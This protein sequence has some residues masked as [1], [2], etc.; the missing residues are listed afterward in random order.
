MFDKKR[1]LLALFVYWPLCLSAAATPVLSFVGTFDNATRIGPHQDVALKVLPQSL[2]RPGPKNRQIANFTE[3]PSCGLVVPTTESWKQYHTEI[4]KWFEEQWVLFQKNPGYKSLPLYLRDQFAPNAAPSSQFCDTF[5]TCSIISCSNL[6]EDLSQHDKQMAYFVFEQ[7]SGLDHMFHRMSKKLKENRKTEQLIMSIVQAYGLL[8]AGYVGLDIPVIPFK[9][10]FLFEL[11]IYLGISHVLNT[12]W[13]EVPNIDGDLEASFRGSLNEL[14]HRSTQCIT[15]EMRDFMSGETNRLEQNMSSIMKGEDFFAPDPNLTIRVKRDCEKIMFAV[16]VNALWRFDRAYILDTDAPPSGCESDTRGPSQ[17]R[18]CLPEF[19]KK[20]FWLYALNPSQEGDTSDQAQAS[21][22]IG[23]RNFFNETERYYN[24]TMKD[25]VR[26]SLFTHQNGL[27]EAI[28]KIDFKRMG[29]AASGNKTLGKVPATFTVPVC[30]NPGGE[31]ITSVW[32]DKGR[33]YPC[34]CGEF[35]WNDGTWSI[36][37]DETKKFL[38]FSSFM[39]SEDWEDYCSSHNHCKGQNDIDWHSDFERMRKEGDPEIPED[40]KHPFKKC[41]ESKKHSI[42]D[43]D[44]DFDNK[45]RAAVEQD[46]GDEKGVKL[47]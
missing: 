33:N 43:P 15:Q 30:R 18:V 12:A 32:S 16:A 21:G 4:K 6:K 22:P 3:N 19:S 25:I 40:L 44:K 39:F 5:G 24:I 41:K 14:Q 31:S 27:Q 17:N 36:Q 26:S 37:K 29:E 2:S 42:G 13:G 47:I 11:N 34:M 45:T 8:G 10:V 1:A 35:G 28:E 20:T 38:E 46:M 9:E 23:Y 7:I